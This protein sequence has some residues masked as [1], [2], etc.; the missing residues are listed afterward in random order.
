MQGPAAGGSSAGMSIHKAEGL[1]PINDKC[2]SNIPGLY[3]AGDALD[4]YMAGAI[5]TQIGSSLA[6]SAVQGAIAAEAAAAYSEHLEMPTVPPKSRD[7]IQNEILVPLKRDAGYGP[8]WVTQTLQ[9]IMIPNFVIYIK[10]ESILKAALAYIE[11]LR[12]HHMPMLRAADIGSGE[13]C[14]LRVPDHG[15]AAHHC[16]L[17]V[18][19]GGIA[20]HNLARHG[21]TYVDGEAIRGT[22]RL[23][24]GAM[25]R[26]GPLT[27]EIQFDPEEL[28]ST[29]LL[30]AMQEPDTEQ[31][32]PEVESPEP[33]G[34]RIVG[35]CKSREVTACASPSEAAAG[36]LSQ[37]LHRG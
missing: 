25:L 36:V 27:L 35:V 23:Q 26:V 14:A 1:V 16:A 31:R 6:G 30:D 2:E 11:E 33:C 4:S 7:L 21:H 24:P 15:V 3:A 5:Y 32:S 12:D 28:A 19:G 18:S 13:D 34:T 37:F 10:K 9:G 29:A 20:V 8:A 22:R 17:F